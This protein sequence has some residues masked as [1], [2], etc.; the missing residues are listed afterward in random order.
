ML[1]EVSKSE[2]TLNQNNQIIGGQLFE[3]LEIIQS[4]RRR[5]PGPPIRLFELFKS[6]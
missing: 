1:A 5:E 6:H 4:P 3:L 2:Y